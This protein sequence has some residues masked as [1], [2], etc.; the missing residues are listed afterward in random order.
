MALRR[1]LRRGA[2]DDAGMTLI[3]L[4]VAMGVFT[5][6]VSVFMAGIVIMTRST[7]RTDVTAASGDSV[8][9][10]FERLDRQVRYAESINYP[11]TGVSG[12]VYVEFRVSATVSSNGK[13]MCT[14]WRWD[15]ATQHLERRS[16]EDAPGVVPAAWSVVA[17]KVLADS[18]TSGRP[19]PFQ[20]STASATEP[21]Q[22]LT[23]R[24]TVGSL[25]V[26]TTI[27]SETTFSA[28]NSSTKSLS[29]ADVDGNGQSD[30]PVCLSA[31]GRP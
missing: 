22:R 31:G 13:A 2:A 27:D 28:R 3:E 26:G 23:L 9:T 17:T 16:W 12:A 7:V 29:N 1:R 10:V 11:G 19:Y 4:I 8:R 25:P 24:L 20:V 30:I 18:D 14:Q 6:L 5:V 15:P 21:R